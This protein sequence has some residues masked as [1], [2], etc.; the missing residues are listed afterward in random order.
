M[1]KETMNHEERLNAAIHLQPVDR[2]PVGP[3]I[4]SYSA[5]LQGM[6]QA[7]MY[8]DPK[9]SIEGFKKTY[10]FHGGWDVL[11]AGALNPDPIPFSFVLP[12]R[13]NMPGKELDD[14]AQLQHDESAPIIS[15]EDYDKII[16]MGWM[17]FAFK[18][19]MPVMFPGHGG[20][21]LGML[22]AGFR[23]KK[24]A[25]DN[26][27]AVAYWNDRGVP[28][29]IGGQAQT[30]FE[31]L[32]LGRTLNNFFIDLYRHPEKVIETMDAI[33]P[34]VLG[35][36]LTNSERTGI[37]RVFIGGTR[38]SNTF[39]SQEQFDK[40]YFPY[41]KQLVDDLVE[42]G[43][44]PMLHF[45]TD[46]TVFLPRFLEL[47]KGKCFLHLDSATDIFK[48]KEI[49]QGHMCIMGDVPATL[50]KLGSVEEVTAYCKKLIDVVGKGSGFILAAGC[51]VPIDAKP[52]NVQA[53]IDTAKNYYPHN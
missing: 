2:V 41:L 43:L 25:G 14:D 39:I 20:G 12:T 35:M 4:S 37:K 50:L 46:W 49:L 45:D 51:T 17:K 24:K 5:R 27:K 52:E 21:P 26:K 42:K 9:A 44:N 32:A 11:G 1:I 31:L 15:F 19:F 6:T 28:I 10:E 13:I 30:G 36:C 38:G 16:E 3:M 48:A 53:M 40:F 22:K 47:P 7:Q 23:L 34:D 18:H 8:A 29:I 33:A